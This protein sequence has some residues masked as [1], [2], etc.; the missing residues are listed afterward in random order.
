MFRKEWG[1]DFAASR[2][3]VLRRGGLDSDSIA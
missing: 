2:L 3:R 1:C